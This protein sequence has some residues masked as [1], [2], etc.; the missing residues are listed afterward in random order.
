MRRACAL[1]IV[2]AGL[3]RVASADPISF[4]TAIDALGSINERGRAPSFAQFVELLKRN[5][6][7]LSGPEFHQL[8]KLLLEMQ[9]P[10]ISKNELAKRIA[11]RRQTISNYVA[12][13]TDKDI[14]TGVER[15]YEFI[16]RG[17]KCLSRRWNLPGNGQSTLERAIS[18]DGQVVRD[19]KP[20]GNQGR[21][22]P[23]DE[24]S[25]QSLY[26]PHSNPMGSSMLMDAKSQLG[27]EWLLD[28]DLARLLESDETILYSQRQ[29]VDGQSCLVVDHLTTVAYLNPEL[30]YSVIRREHWTYDD[31]NGGPLSRSKR[32]MRCEDFQE[33][34][35][36]WLFP[37]K[38]IYEEPSTG[39][40]DVVTVDKL[41]INGGVLEGVFQSDIFPDGIEIYETLP[42]GTIIQRR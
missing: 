37:R 26:E 29:E 20:P 31:K 16:V 5:D 1:V 6:I 17:H 41:V 7:Q 30:G 19:F 24:S 10:E 28:V 13:V 42:D 23:L 25:R 4:V 32:W 36:G 12:D 38:V 21:M 11:T 22:Y 39:K 34:G 40:G 9:Q 35:D 18:Y 14:E 2:F 33:F 8:R 3:C 15:R 27:E